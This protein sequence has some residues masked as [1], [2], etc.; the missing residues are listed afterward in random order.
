[1]LTAAVCFDGVDDEALVEAA[2]DLLRC[3]ERVES[4]CA[5]GD[6]AQRLLDDAGERHH[7]PPHHR[8]HPHHYE[9]ADAEQAE[10]IAAHGV[11]LLQRAGFTAVARTYRGIDAGHALARASNA[12]HA[13]ILAAGHRESTGPKSVGHVARFVVDHAR[14]P[15][16]VV[17]PGGNSG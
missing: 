14:G 15:V 17:R 9:T 8:P 7:G 5:Y 10:A 3:F 11:T 1:M 6:E 4:W 2:L 12:E 16:I 13:L